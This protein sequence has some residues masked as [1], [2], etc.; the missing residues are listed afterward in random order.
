M[1]NEL[2]IYMV[3]VVDFRD[4]ETKRIRLYDDLQLLQNDV[5]K[6]SDNKQMGVIKSYEYKRLSMESLEIKTLDGISKYMDL[7]TFT[8]LMK[9]LLRES[10]IKTF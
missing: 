8:K 3:T 6:L 9:Y 1:I 7:G 5:D 2:S 10:T 4:E